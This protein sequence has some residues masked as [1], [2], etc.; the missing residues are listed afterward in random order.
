[1]YGRKILFMFSFF[2]DGKIL[3]DF[4]GM[5][6]VWLFSVGEKPQI[7]YRI[8]S[9]MVFMSF[10]FSPEMALSTDFVLLRLMAT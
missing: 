1:M 8:G 6:V 3:S 2:S 5:F 4:T 9:M 10:I 7:V